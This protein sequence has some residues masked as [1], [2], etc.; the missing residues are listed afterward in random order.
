MSLAE[1]LRDAR[2]DGPFNVVSVHLLAEAADEL[3]RL[4]RALEEVRA[5]ADVCGFGPDSYIYID[6]LY[7]IRRTADEALAIYI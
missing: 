5:A 3:E 7:D 2:G 1:R 4:R 6:L